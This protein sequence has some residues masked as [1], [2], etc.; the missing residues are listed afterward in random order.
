MQEY[1][2]TLSHCHL[3]YPCFFA[4]ELEFSGWTCRQDLIFSRPFSSRAHLV[5]LGV[6]KSSNL[7]RAFWEVSPVAWHSFEET[8]YCSNPPSWLHSWLPHRSVPNSCSSIF[9]P[10]WVSQSQTALESSLNQPSAPATKEPIKILELKVVSAI[11]SQGDPLEE[12]ACFNIHR[13]W[14]KIIG[15]TKQTYTS[16]AVTLWLNAVFGHL[17][18]KP[19]LPTFGSEVCACKTHPRVSLAA[20]CG[21][22][23]VG[24]QH[25][26]SIYTKWWFQPIAHL[27]NTQIGSFP[28]VE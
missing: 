22:T 4:Q 5:G 12:V 17:L 7:S 10:R 19:L 9:W 20:P 23:C 13:K 8:I 27:K 15:I 26:T 25:V 3:Q 16:P 2:W 11:L 28:Q 24:W 6:L 21:G 14:V 1:R 18:P